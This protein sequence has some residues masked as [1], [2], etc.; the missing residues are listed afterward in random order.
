MAKSLSQLI[1]AYGDRVR[2]K[3][4]DVARSETGQLRDEIIKGWPVDTGASRA[5]WQGP[6]QK[7]YAF[8]ELRNEYPYAA[9]I[10][11]GGY[12]GVGPKTEK[13]GAH[14]LPGGIQ[15]R[16]GIYPSQK[17]AAPLARAISKRIVAFKTELGAVIRVG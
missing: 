15:V 12:P 10:E 16:G 14:V 3:V 7:G 4:N 17:P 6:L 1:R 2:A 13:V 9:T 11:Y 5:G 8:Y